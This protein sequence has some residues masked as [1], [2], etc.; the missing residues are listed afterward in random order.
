MSTASDPLASTAPFAS[1]HRRVIAEPALFAQLEAAADA[2]A[3]IPKALEL[4]KSI[5]L[6][7]DAE[8]VRHALHA[9][10]RG[11]IE[12]NLPLPR[13]G[14]SAPADD[15]ASLSGWTPLRVFPAD[16]EVRIDWCRTGAERFTDSFFEQTI[17]RALRNP[18]RLLFRRETPIES[19]EHFTR[20]G[21]GPT[22]TGFIFHLSR[23][24]STH[25]A[26]Q[27]A[28]LP[29]SVVISEAPPLDQ[30]LT[31]LRRDSRASHGQ[32][33]ARFCGMVHALGQKR[34][35]EDREYFIKF[36]SW[37]VLELPFILAAFPEVPWIFLYR[38]PVEVMVSHHR[39]R[40][41]QMIPGIVDPHLFGIEPAEMA[42]LSLDEYCARVLA[43]ICAAA[44]ACSQLGRGRLVNFS[45]LPTLL[46]GPL[47]DFFG[48]EHTADDRER[49]HQAA[50]RNSKTPSLPY[51]DDAA[52]KQ[53]QA[54]AEIRRLADVWLRDL[55]D[56]LETRRRAQSALRE[57]CSRELEAAVSAA[58]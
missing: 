12:R 10:R 31:V 15:G 8:C 11:W 19:L 46:P 29:R 7:F 47:L 43:R 21:P 37:H 9:A 38:D 1:F 34:R 22:P 33:R 45:E 35:A 48:L 18:A 17:A 41:T 56:T 25:V 57:A 28:A 52:A 20:E 32:R 5:G 4:A 55:Y 44:V 6:G 2:D 51:V 36:D 42:N 49:L 39:Q 14:A 30:L 58:E 16:G 13:G 3:F 54:T 24:G 50:P 26:Q 40:G 23:C 53:K 27:L